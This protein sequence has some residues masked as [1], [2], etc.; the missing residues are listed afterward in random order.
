MLY[1]IEIASSPGHSQLQSFLAYNIES[2]E[3]FGDEA[4]V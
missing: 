2:W 3:L 1:R 4:S